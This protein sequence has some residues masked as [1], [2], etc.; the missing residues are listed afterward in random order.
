[1]PSLREPV[2]DP[3]AAA[4]QV[5]TAYAHNDHVGFE[6]SEAVVSKKW[7]GTEADKKDM[8]QLGKVQELRVGESV[9]KQ[10][11]LCLLTTLSATLTSSA[12]LGSRVVLSRLGKSF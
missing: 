10:V 11:R 7:Q 9:T 2:D 8:S 3:K 5:R 12:F 1:M 4:Q 6:M